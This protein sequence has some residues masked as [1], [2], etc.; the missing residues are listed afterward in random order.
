M[1][2]THLNRLWYSEHFINIIFFL[3]KNRKILDYL[4]LSKSRLVSWKWEILIQFPAN[5]RPNSTT[6]NLRLFS[7]FGTRWE[8][9]EM[10]A[11]LFSCNDLLLCCVNRP[12][13]LLMFF[14]KFASYKSIRPLWNLIEL[15]WLSKKKLLLNRQRQF[16]VWPWIAKG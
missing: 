7:K 6:Q 5:S 13:A 14:N 16:D 9:F 15:N 10:A 2:R 8:I 11:M 12:T 4:V 1:W 3:S